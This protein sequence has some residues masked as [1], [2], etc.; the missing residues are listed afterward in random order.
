MRDQKFTNS[1]ATDFN[2]NGTGVSGHMHFVPAFGPD[3]LLMILGGNNNSDHQYSFDAITLYDTATRR[4]FNQTTVGNVPKGRQDFCVAGVSSA[5]GTYEIF[6]YGGTSG[7]LGPEGVPYDEIYLLTLPAFYWFKIQY[8]PRNPRGGHTCN[9]VGESQILSIGGYDANATVYIDATF[10]HVR[11]SM[12]NSTDPFAQGLGVFNMTSL[13]WEDHYTANAPA[14]AQSEPIKL[15]YAE[16]P[17]DGSQFSTNELKELFDTTH[18]TAV[19]GPGSN[20]TD[21]SPPDPP[22]NIAGVIAGGVVGGLAGLAI[23][24]GIGFYFYKRMKR[25]NAAPDPNNGVIAAT[26]GPKYVLHPLAE[27]DQGAGFGGAQLE[28]QGIQEME[29]YPTEMAAH[30]SFAEGHDQSERRYELEAAQ[31]RR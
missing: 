21:D 8:P 31:R 26:L 24:A 27:A 10:D 11:E 28:G 6:L 4:W 9:A 3:G 25:R 23:V 2:A 22:S 14:Y 29:Q 5:E 20:S 7:H 15:F 30:G 1:S 13:V 12:F 16:H 19:G 18:F 17:Q